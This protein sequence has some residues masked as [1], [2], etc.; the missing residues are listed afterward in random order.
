MDE[1]VNDKHG[2]LLSKLKA[3]CY[4]NVIPD[5]LYESEAFIC[6]ALKGAVSAARRAWKPPACPPLEGS[7]LG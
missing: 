2:L 3:F 7:S 5:F 1:Y 6:K 4:T